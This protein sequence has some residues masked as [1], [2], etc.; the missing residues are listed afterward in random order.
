M[1]APHFRT[2]LVL[3]GRKVDLTRPALMGVVNANVD[4]FSDPGELPTLDR[5]L[6]RVGELVDGG[7]TIID[8][9]G[10]SG[11][12]GVP[13]AD[14]GDERD[15]VVPLVAAIA[16]QHPRIVISVDTYKPV[17][18]AA[19]LMAGATIVNDVSGLLDPRLATI[20]GRHGAGLVVMHTRARPKQ[21]LQDPDRYGAEVVADVRDFLAEKV[22]QAIELGVDERSIVV[23]P[24]PDFSKTPHQ[25]VEVLRHL[26]EVNPAGLPML[27]AISRK[28][29][30]GAITATPPRERLAGTLAAVAAVG[31]GSGVILRV[32]DVAEVARFLAVLQVLRGEAEIA[33]DLALPDTL[34]WSNRPPEA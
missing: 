29:F 14:P 30:I 27:L 20:A 32:H 26:P 28:D 19:S 23:D 17:V 2:D 15:L 8:V 11:I 12:T 3:A 21:R 18:A 6:A 1:D 31:T 4:S 5:Q 22:A 13:E 34:R 25:T 24:G 10:Q 16:A 33:E 7:A 9:G